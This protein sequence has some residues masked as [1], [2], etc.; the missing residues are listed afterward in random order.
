MSL[1]FKT[2]KHNGPSCL[3][4]DQITTVLTNWSSANSLHRVLCSQ[5]YLSMT[6]GSSSL[7]PNDKLNE[8]SEQAIINGDL[9]NSQKTQHMETSAT[10]VHI[11]LSVDQSALNTHLALLVFTQDKSHHS[12]TTQVQLLE[13]PGDPPSTASSLPSQGVCNPALG[14]Y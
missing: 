14:F 1:C 10:L 12:S 2:L 7:P 3:V 6:A 8:R 5:S 13:L 11:S 9:H 4:S